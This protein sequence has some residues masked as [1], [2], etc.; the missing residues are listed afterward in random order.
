MATPQEE[1]LPQIASLLNIAALDTSPNS[2]S[3]SGGRNNSGEQ[4]SS[5]RTSSQVLAL[6]RLPSSSGMLWAP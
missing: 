2:G 6:Q 3:G 1:A 5:E 4:L